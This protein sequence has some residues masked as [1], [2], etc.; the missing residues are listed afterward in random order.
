MKEHNEAEKD[1][2]TL[3]EKLA[4]RCPECNG[5]G[6]VTPSMWCD[7]CVAATGYPRPKQV[8]CMKCFGTGELEAKSDNDQKRWQHNSNAGR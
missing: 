2:M 8:Q 1:A 3:A 7:I 5:T 4:A 6:R